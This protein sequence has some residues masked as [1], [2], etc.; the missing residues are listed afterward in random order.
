MLLDG[1]NRR[2]A[3]D[4]FVTSD[5]RVSAAVTAAIENFMLTTDGKSS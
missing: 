5:A 4:G 1:L 2:R 3:T